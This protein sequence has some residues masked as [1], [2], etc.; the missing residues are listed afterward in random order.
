MKETGSL[1]WLER[2]GKLVLQQEWGK[3]NNWA[4]YN[5]EWRDVPTV[6]ESK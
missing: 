2:D 1:R 4:W 6:K 3:Q 5:L